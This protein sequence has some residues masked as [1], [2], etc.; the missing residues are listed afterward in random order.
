M[1]KQFRRVVPT[2]VALSLAALCLSS[3]LP[4]MAQVDT[5]V[6]HIGVD[7]TGSF[8]I[9]NIVSFLGGDARF[10]SVGVIDVDASGVPT[11]GQLSAYDS[12]LVATDNRVG[13]LTGGGLGTQLGNILDD[14]VLGG[15][16]VVMS[17][18]SGNT[19]LGVD[20]DILT[21]AP[22]VLAGENASAGLLDMAGANLAHPVFSGVS[23]FNSTFASNVNVSGIGILLGS[24]FSGTEAVLTVADDSVMM[25]NGFPATQF[26][27]SNGSDFGHLFANALALNGQAP[28][29]V[30]EPC[31]LAVL[32]AGALG[33]VRAARRRRQTAI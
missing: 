13:T 4:A 7:D 19:S 16:R 10:S 2:V 6:V 27:F 32:G 12:I 30:P 17:T 23:S 29:P 24:Y 1:F 33:A 28:P 3:G 8:G 31:S 26:D 22:Y 11:V 14:Y 9:S 25:I 5:A 15:G 20:G 18:F 21:L